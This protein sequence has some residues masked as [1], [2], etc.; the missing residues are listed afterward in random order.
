MSARKRIR[1]GVIFDPLFGYRAVCEVDGERSYVG[2]WT[3]EAKALALADESTR[4]WHAAIDSHGIRKAKGDTP[5]G[6]WAP[7]ERST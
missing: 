5:L 2:P 4:A 1:H 3:T 7:G 6:V